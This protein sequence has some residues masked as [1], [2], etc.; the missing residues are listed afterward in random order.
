MKVE[1]L[2]SVTIEG[3]VFPPCAVIDIYQPEAEALVSAGKA[4]W[5][6]DG[7]MARIKS[8]NAPGCLPPETSNK[9]TQKK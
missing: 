7:T 2:K 1:L 6:P 5:V 3:R 9:Q 8:Y 4:K